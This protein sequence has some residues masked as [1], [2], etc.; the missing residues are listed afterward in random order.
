MKDYEKVE[1]L[2]DYL[3]EGYDRKDPDYIAAKPFLDNIRELFVDCYSYSDLCVWLVEH[4]MDILIN[5][6]Y[7]KIVRKE[8]YKNPDD[9]EEAKEDALL[10][11][12]DGTSA[13]KSWFQLSNGEHSKK[14]N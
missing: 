2:V 7:A 8:D 12:D 9:W 11:S 13:V 3:L 10:V 14:L 5:F 6:R 1:A 4:K